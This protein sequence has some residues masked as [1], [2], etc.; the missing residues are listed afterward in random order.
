MDTKVNSQLILTTFLKTATA[1]LVGAC[2]CII[3]AVGLFPR[4][5]FSV[6][7]DL[8]MYEAVTTGYEKLYKQ[9]ESYGDLYNLINVASSAKDY[10]VLNTYARKFI[11]D[12]GE[13]KSKF[14][15]DID[16]SVIDACDLKEVAYVY[17]VENYILNQAII[18][19]YYCEGYE[20][21][22]V[23]AMSALYDGKF[24]KH[25]FCFALDTYLDLVHE[26]MS[27][28][29][30]KA[31][32]IYLYNFSVGDKNMTD[33]FD[34]KIN[35]I[36]SQAN[37]LSDVLTNRSSLKTRLALDRVL[38]VVMQTEKDIL[39]GVLDVVD[40]SA[41]VES[42]IESLASEI[43]SLRIEYNNLIQM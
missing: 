24:D 19:T 10:K 37:V 27:S 38:M 6:M 30:V 17:S 16:Q 32:Y 5:T 21:A 28:E 7:R 14:V 9:T 35:S 15:T 13:A 29:Q 43:N 20:N 26:N 12:E 31:E 34:K 23:F 41:S 4:A 22:R 11:S 33:I 3:M 25:N 8:H 18:G 36:K 2:F 40:D 42:Q 1:L 39:S